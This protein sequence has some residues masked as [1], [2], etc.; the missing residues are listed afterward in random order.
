MII[1]YSR[2]RLGNQI[3]QYSF[4][5]KVKKDENVIVFGF[6]ELLDVFE[7][8]DIKAYSLEKKSSKLIIL[9]IVIPILIFLS[10]S[11]IITSFKLLYD[12]PLY[13]VDRIIRRESTKIKIVNGL[14]KS[15][16][17]IY[18]NF[19]QSEKF[20][21]NF[22]EKKLKIKEIY[23]KEALKLFQDIPQNSHK[24]FVHVRLG[25]YK[26][27]NLYNNSIIL[28]QEYYLN[29]INYFEKKYNNCFFIFLSDEPWEVEKIFRNVKR[30]FISF[31][32]AVGVDFALMCL[33][34]SAI[35]SAS[36][37]SW[38]GAYFIRKKG[39]EIFAPKYWLGFSSKI[40]THEGSFPSFA[41]EIEI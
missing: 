41:K 38:W 25:D 8:N 26:N 3:F 11:R 20:V 15:I 27:Y 7:I 6:S 13:V 39:G 21:P 40:E 24:I 17:F 23:L 35:L 19:F 32:P 12:E 10:K 33:C 28:P 5:Q 22:I 37:L 9:K 29:L 30:K 34:D 31:N 16:K 18:P 14:I 36:S 1:F 4:I 2:G